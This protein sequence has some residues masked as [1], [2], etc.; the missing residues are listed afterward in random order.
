M[1][2][3]IFNVN[4]PEYFYAKSVGNKFFCVSVDIG[5]YKGDVVIT[6]DHISKGRKTLFYSHHFHIVWKRITY[7]LKNRLIVLANQKISSFFDISSTAKK[8]LRTKQPVFLK[9]SFSSF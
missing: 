9:P 1:W 6:G 4:L 5:V 7:V 2:L 3:F 8:I